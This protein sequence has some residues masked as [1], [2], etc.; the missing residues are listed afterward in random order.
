MTY[1][2]QGEVVEEIVVALRGDLLVRRWRVDLH[3]EGETPSLGF[4][5]SLSAAEFFGSQKKLEIKF[6]L[7]L[8]N[9]AGGGLE[10]TFTPGPCELHQP[11]LQTCKRPYGGSPELP[12]HPDRNLQSRCSSPET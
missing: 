1:H 8:K 4:G 5:L 7:N 9:R 2:S 10:F 11:C 3:L 6:K 12:E